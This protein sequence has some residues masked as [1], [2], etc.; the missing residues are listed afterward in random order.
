MASAPPLILVLYREVGYESILDT[1][2][3]CMC[4]PST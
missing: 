1:I 4:I 2:L 3:L